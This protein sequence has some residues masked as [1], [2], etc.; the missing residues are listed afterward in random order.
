[1]PVE[2]PAKGLACR[3]SVDEREAP[4]VCRVD[5]N[6]ERKETMKKAVSGA[7]APRS[8]VRGRRRGIKTTHRA[9]RWK[10]D[11]NAAWKGFVR[12][13]KTALM[14]VGFVTLLILIANWL[15]GG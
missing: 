14:A 6:D 11:L 8:A 2:A 12:S 9:P 7:Q 10:R 4:E 1:M 3:I 15:G 13:A 5:Q